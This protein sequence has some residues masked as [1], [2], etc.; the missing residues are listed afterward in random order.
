MTSLGTL[1]NF[2]WA[3]EIPAEFSMDASEVTALQRP[4][5][6]YLLLPRMSF[7]P[8]VA[9]ILA[10]H[11]GDVAPDAQRTLWLEDGGTGEP[12]RW[13]VPTGVLFDLF[14]RKGVGQRKDSGAPGG[15][16]PWRINVHFQG[17]PRQQVLPLENE[18][19]IRRHYTNA[20]KQALF[21][22]SGS[23][24]SVMSLS[25]ENQTR[26]WEA[27]KGCN[28]CVFHEV[29]TFLGSRNDRALPRLV[30]VR[31]IRGKAPPVQLPF[32]AKR[33]ND[34]FPSEEGGGSTSD[35]GEEPTNGEGVP[36]ESEDKKGDAAVDKAS[37]GVNDSLEGNTAGG[38]GEGRSSED[39]VG[40]A[41]SVV[42]QGINPPLDVSITDL[43][44][45]L[46]HP[47][48]FLYVVVLG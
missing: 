6:L 26:L 25:K 37:T 5:P 15:V 48:H 7:L 17:R 41:W 19:D 16:L 33:P 28:G 3:G 40:A 38:K 20:L 14:V 11:F 36:G 34:I 24:K 35:D 42:I 32:P 47:D 27:I 12:L 1:R 18:V 8:C 10:H 4:L 9:E 22:Q 21:M 39:D 45:A 31:I 13:H 44:V 43:W 46:R 23:S 2:I 30:P 29:D